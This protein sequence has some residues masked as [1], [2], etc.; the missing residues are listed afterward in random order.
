MAVPMSEVQHDQAGIT[1]LMSVT[2]PGDDPADVAA[3]LGRLLRAISDALGGQAA[4]LQAVDPREGRFAVV[5]SVNFS[6]EPFDLHDAPVGE[7][8]AGQAHNEG[9]EIEVEAGALPRAL[10]DAGLRHAV[11]L[12]VRTPERSHG[13]I[14]VA[15]AHPLSGEPLCRHAAR[16]GAERVAAL[17]EQLRLTET[18]ERAMAQILEGDERMLGRI[19]LDIHDGPTQQ[20]SVALL[21]VQLLEAEVDDLDRAGETVPE[22]LR[23]GLGRIYETL[24]GALQEMRELIGHLRPAQFENNILPDVLRGAV[25]SFATQSGV[26]VDFEARGEF[27]DVQVSLTQKIT[28][29]RILQEALNNAGRHGQASEI[30]VRLR[31]GPAGITLEVRDNGRGFDPAAIQRPSSS[32]PQARYDLYGMRDRAQLLG[33]SLDVSSSRGQGSIITVFLPR[34]RGSERGRVGQIG[35]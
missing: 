17:F 13:V 22:R 4:V 35:G 33:G 23:D 18:L 6:G 10:A 16:V 11:A 5:D 27:P 20:L 31:E 34:W 15:G 3:E 12:P 25:R 21:E 26:I 32:N 1:A 28:F 19:G 2:T 14:W 9:L 30:S 8:P 24:G 7:G 29:Y